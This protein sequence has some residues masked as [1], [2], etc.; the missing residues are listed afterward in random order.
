MA[1]I[2][3]RGDIV[4][5]SAPG[6][7]GKPRPAVIVQTDAL[8]EAGLQSVVVC[9]MSSA[10]L[11]APLF[12]IPVEASPVSGLDKPSQIMVDKLFTLP[13]EKVTKVIGKI[14]EEQRMQLNRKLAF[15]VGLG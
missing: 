15:V 11:R 8:I 7:Y 14:T 12:R 10:D 5:L 13:T 1:G 9:L 6:D 2:M 4:I 3:R